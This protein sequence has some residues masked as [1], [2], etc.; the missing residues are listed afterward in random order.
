MIDDADRFE[1]LYLYL[2]TYCFEYGPRQLS[3]SKPSDKRRV[4]PTNE[5]RKPS[6]AVYLAAFRSRLP[7]SRNRLPLEAVNPKYLVNEWTSL[8]LTRKLVSLNAAHKP[9]ETVYLAPDVVYL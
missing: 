5:A 6:E 9:S 3:T 8:T 4:G 2:G 1:C 7:C